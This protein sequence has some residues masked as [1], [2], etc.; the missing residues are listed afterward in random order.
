[1]LQKQNAKNSKEKKDPYGPERSHMYNALRIAWRDYYNLSKEQI[2][3]KK[4]ISNH[5]RVIRKLQNNLRKPLT[6]FIMFEAVAWGF[7]KLNPEL[8]KD[9]TNDLVEKAIIKTNAILGSGMRLDIRPN[10]VE[11]LIR[12]NNALFRYIA[13]TGVASKSDAS[14]NTPKA[15]EANL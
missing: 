9:I 14:P 7:Y 13:E 10:M 3:D 2:L 11:E 15:D 12:R 1:M 8:F 5:K 4:I 6:P